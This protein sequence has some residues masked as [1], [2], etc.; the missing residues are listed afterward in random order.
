MY[1]FE[2]IVLPTLDGDNKAVFT[3]SP[4]FYLKNILTQIYLY[5][6]NRAKKKVDW[7]LS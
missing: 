6:I 3:A 5:N 4:E 2:Q 1:Y 7:S